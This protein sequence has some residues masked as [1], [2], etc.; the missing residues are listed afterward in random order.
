M[1]IASEKRPAMFKFYTKTADG[2]LVDQNGTSVFFSFEKFRDEIC[3]KGHCFVCGAK[4]DRTFNDE[5]VIPNWLQRHC[6][7]QKE[8]LDLPNAQKATYGT[9]KIACCSNCN[10]L[11]GEVY[12][13]PISEVVKGGQAAVVNFI[14][15]GG[16]ALLSG[17]LGLIFLK[18]HLRDFRNRVSLDKRGP[19]GFIGDNYDLHELHHVHAVARAVTAGIEIDQGVFGTLLILDVGSD[20]GAFDYCD[21]L[22]GRTLLLQVNE[23]AFV[24]VIDD[25]GATS[26]ML[27]DQLAVLP[28]PINQIQLREVYARHLTANLHIVSSPTFA[29]VISRET[30]LPRITVDL[31]E[32][33]ARD[34]EPTVFGRAFS[35]A[36]GNLRT[37]IEIDGKRGDA[38]MAVIETGRVSSIFT[39]GG[40]VRD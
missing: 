27:K 28:H 18:V 17:W 26:T 30:G 11:L 24:H 39:D 8:S 5:H 33:E 21:N 19:D 36:L 32:F 34:F 6:D 1:A 2:S 4:P 14:E 16:A 23:M 40:K 31:P 20:A 9:Y 29:T 25:C 37:E 35:G 38:A 15:N 10:S 13:T 22:A 12:E 7:I 3:Q